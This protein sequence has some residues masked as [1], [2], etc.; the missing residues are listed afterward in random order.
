LRIYSDAKE[1]LNETTREVFSRGHIVFDETLQGKKV[2]RRYEAKELLGYNFTLT[3]H[4]CHSI[5]PMLNWGKQ[6]FK[7]PHLT[8]EY[9]REWFLATHLKDS[10]AEVA[11]HYKYY[12]EYWNQFG[13]WIYSYAERVGERLDAAITLLR[14]NKY[15]RGVVIPIYEPQDI[16]YLLRNRRVPC[17]LYYQP[18]IRRQGPDDL[19]HLVYGMRSCDLVNWF[20]LDVCRAVFTKSYLAK[21]LNVKPGSLIMHITSLHAHRIDV[22]NDRQW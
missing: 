13:D 18:I 15:R 19:L 7:K 20:P 17:S 5:T 4:G 2:D 8:L 1:M 6:Q 9:A 10:K 11:A 22:P 16:P 3:R 12:P 14:E 21:H